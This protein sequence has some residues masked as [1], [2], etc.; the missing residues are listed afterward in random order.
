[1]KNQGNLVRFCIPTHDLIEFQNPC[2]GISSVSVVGSYRTIDFLHLILQY[3]M[4]L[5]EEEGFIK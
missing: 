2:R 3:P 5:M 4:I 1:M